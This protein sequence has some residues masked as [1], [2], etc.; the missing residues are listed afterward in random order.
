MVWRLLHVVV[1][2]ALVLAAADVYKIKYESTLQAEKVSKLR[3][4]VRREQDAIAN[5]RAEWSKL[6][7]PDRLQ[8]LAQRHLTLKPVEARQFDA[9]DRLPARPVELVPP[10]TADPIGALVE[11]FADTEALT[12]SLPDGGAKPN[13]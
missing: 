7:R 5:L 13:E 1:L 11:I 8:A 3:A 2:A 10:G 6:D 4:D 9:L 12:G